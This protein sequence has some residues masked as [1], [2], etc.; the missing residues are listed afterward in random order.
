MASCPPNRPASAVSRERG[1]C[2]GTRGWTANS[3]AEQEAPRQGRR[4]ALEQLGKHRVIAAAQTARQWAGLRPPGVFV[5]QHHLGP[6]PSPQ[7]PPLS[8]HSRPSPRGG[9]RLLAWP[10]S[11][12]HPPAKPNPTLSSPLVGSGKTPDASLGLFISARIGDQHTRLSLM[13]LLL[14]IPFGPCYQQSLLSTQGFFGTHPARP[15]LSC[16]L[17]L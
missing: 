12:P 15:I 4:A 17:F 13:S 10:P 1:E 2:A 7:A 14:Q 6:A 5:Y 16:L 3:G 11:V 8:P 9:L